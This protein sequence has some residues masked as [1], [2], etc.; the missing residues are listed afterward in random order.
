M[1]TLFQIDKSGNDIYEKDYSLILLLNKKEVYGVNI[2][3]K[4]KD[5]LI[6]MLR[7]DQLNINASTDKAKR[8]RLKIRLHTAVIIILIERAIKDPG[9]FDDINIELCN[10][11]DGHFHEIK[12]MIFKHF[13]KIIPKLKPED[14]VLTKFQ[15]PSLI[16]EAGKAFRNNDRN[17]INQYNQV[18]LNL[19]ELIKIIKK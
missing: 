12:D 6:S 15:K 14:I 18:N 13:V 1:I 19:N 7:K 5:H 8:K 16:D 2:P 11:I 4:I 17:K 9:L 10:D 3:Q